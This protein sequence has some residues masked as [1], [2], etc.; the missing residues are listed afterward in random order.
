MFIKAIAQDWIITRTPDRRMSR[1]SVVK[2]GTIVVRNSLFLLLNRCADSLSDH[3][4]VGVIT[5]VNRLNS[6]VQI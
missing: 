1:R 4:H 2:N 6:L 5:R 3:E